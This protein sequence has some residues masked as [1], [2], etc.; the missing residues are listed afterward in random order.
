M[1]LRRAISFTLLAQIVSNT[2]TISAAWVLVTHNLLRWIPILI[3]T[4]GAISALI[5][6]FGSRRQHRHLEEIGAVHAIPP[7][8]ENAAAIERFVNDDS[9]KDLWIVCDCVDYG[10]FSNPKGYDKWLNALLKRKGEGAHIRVL[11]C[12][13]PEAFTRV[14]KLRGM[15]FDELRKTRAFKKYFKVHPALTRPRDEDGFNAILLDRQRDIEREFL[16]KGIL[17]RHLPNEKIG[18]FVWGKDK[19]DVLVIPL[20]GDSEGEGFRIAN[21]LIGDSFRA[22]FER[23]WAKAQRKEDGTKRSRSFRFLR[24]R[25]RKSLRKFR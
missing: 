17:V 1:A 4:Q 22:T 23:L 25:N 2:A 16:D 11:V 24:R 10:S 3:A 19:S 15:T 21:P 6:Y 13:E 14:N 8:P 5:Q 9:C 12:G 7:F 18:L 20:D